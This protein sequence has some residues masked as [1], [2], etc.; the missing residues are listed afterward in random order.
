MQHATQ[1]VAHRRHTGTVVSIAGAKSAVVRVD[2][3]VAHEKYGKF[4]TVSKKFMIDDPASAAH[5][6][7][8]VEFEECR[9]ISRSKRWRYVSTVRSAQA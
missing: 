4:Y 8:V 9:P 1:Q 3:R 6:G 5:V 2:R 7:D